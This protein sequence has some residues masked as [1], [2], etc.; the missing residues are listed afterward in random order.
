M[1]MPRAPSAGRPAAAGAAQ[2]GRARGLPGM[3]RPSWFQDIGSEL[4]KVQWPTRQ[5][6]T[7]LTLVVVVVAAALGLFLGG[8]DA[9]FNWIIEQTLLR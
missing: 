9:G 8:L 1:R 3:L 5:E 2:R 4:K 7:N 6:A